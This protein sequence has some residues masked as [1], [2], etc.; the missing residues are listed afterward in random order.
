MIHD[1][2]H[3]QRE[4]RVRPEELSTLAQLA[5]QVMRLE[6]SKIDYLVDTRRMTFATSYRAT[7]GETP[8]DGGGL[9]SWLTFDGEGHDDI[10]GGPVNEHAH[11]QI[12]ERLN[13]PSRYYDRMRS[14]APELLDVNVQHWF[15]NKPETRMVRMLSGNV[16]AFLSNRYRRLDNIDLLNQAVLPELARHD[17]DLVFH[18][19]ALTPEK[20][21]VRALLP[22]LAREVRPGVGDIVQAGVQITNSEVG[23]GALAVRSFIWKLDCLNG[24][25]SDLGLRRYHVGR[26]QEEAAYALYRDDTLAADDAAFFLKVRDAVG[27]ALSETQFDVIVAAMREA[28]TGEKI[29]DP[30][31]ATERLAKAHTLTDVESGHLLAHLASGGDLSKWGAVNAVTAMAKGADSFARQE[32]LETLGGALLALPEEEWALVA[33]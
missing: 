19:A 9:E 1:G 18:A 12:R 13:I 16:R 22:G 11:R 4:H 26:E 30:V 32:E 25:V 21:Y 28:A 27:A 14:E 23:D 5:E 3:L 6:E 29:A 33:R 15:H 8:G 10:G 20:L 2:P 17:G 31:K 7:G 24:M